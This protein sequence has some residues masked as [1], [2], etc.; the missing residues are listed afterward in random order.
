MKK[1]IIIIFL[2]AL[3]VLINGCQSDK[4]KNINCNDNNPCT[5]DSC[6]LNTG[7]CEYGAKSCPQDKK[8]NINTGNC[9]V[10]N[11]M[12]KIEDAIRKKLRE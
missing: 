12:D 6:D 7:S 9:E 10:I 11:A 3:A 2:I 1:I 4:C 8:C 5:L